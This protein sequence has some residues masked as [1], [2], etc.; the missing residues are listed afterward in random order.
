M[1]QLFKGADQIQLPFLG[2]YPRNIQDISK[3]PRYSIRPA[4]SAE[5]LSAYA[6]GKMFDSLTGILRP[7]TFGDDTRNTDQSVRKSAGHFLAKAD[8]GFRDPAPFFAIV[9]LAVMGHDHPHSQ[10]SRQRRD[11]CGADGM[12]VEDVRAPECRSHD[13]QH[14]VNECLEVFALGGVECNA[15]EIDRLVGGQRRSISGALYH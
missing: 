14:G 2:D 10:N 11:E 6:V 5:L 1:S 9:V 15:F 13:A 7:E 12:D 4:C 8:R 3:V